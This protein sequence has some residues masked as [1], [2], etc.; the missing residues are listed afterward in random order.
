M[1]QCA[2]LDGV[3]RLLAVRRRIC[4]DDELAYDGEQNGLQKPEKGGE[5]L[6]IH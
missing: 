2:K 5:A 6:C 4:H 1:K 3:V